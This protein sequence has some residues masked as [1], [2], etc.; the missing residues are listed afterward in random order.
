MPALVPTQYYA[1]ITWLGKTANR[2]TGLKSEACDAVA[3]T[4]EGIT[5]EARA[6]LTRASCARTTRQHPVGTE[7][8]NVRQLSVL[9]QEELG[10]IAQTLD[11]DDFDPSWLGASMVVQG[12]PD[13]THIPPSSRLQG[14]SGAT[15]VIDMENHPCTL[16]AREVEHARPS[17][18]IGF[19]PAAKGLRGVTMWVERPGTLRV[20]DQLRLHIPN[21][22]AWQPK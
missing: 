16:S 2:T 13:F 19:K 4:Y 12:L 8:R 10:Q 20:D 14:E 22:R 21:Q 18:G 5:G 1:T 9:A 17:H 6:G 3:L 11:F 15:L 7:I